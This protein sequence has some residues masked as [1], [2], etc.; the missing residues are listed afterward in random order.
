[1]TSRMRYNSPDPHGRFAL[2][3]HYEMVADYNRVLPFRK[4]IEQ[5]S[6]GRVVLES[7]TGSAILSLIAAR[8]GAERVYTFE[9]DP[10]VGR[11]AQD[12]IRRS[13]FR[14]VVYTQKDILDVTIADL[15]GRPPGVVIAENL[16][17]WQVTEPEISV[18]NH[19]N[20]S[21][22]IDSTIR[23]P[24]RIMNYLEAVESQYRFEDL[25]DVRT[26]Y[27]QF[28][29]I[30]APNVLSRP[31]LVD[32]VDLREVNPTSIRKTISVEICATGILNSLRLTS[33]LEICQD[34]GFD[35]SD[36]LM[37][38]VVIP[39]QE[40]MWVHRGDRVCIEIRYTAGGDWEH[41]RCTARL[42]D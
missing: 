1:M 33:P 36:S 26:Y 13:G 22:A 32:E 3:Y 20:K 23:L 19:I 39:L 28:S 21:L 14:N 27:F 31:V 9:V 16:S 6:D 17:T 15:D 30:Q 2:P 4:A 41:F 12:N 18:L 40:D 24:T 25:V 37:P 38:P 42:T 5:V 8:A 35:G 29:G 34:I 10:E 11:I 7:G